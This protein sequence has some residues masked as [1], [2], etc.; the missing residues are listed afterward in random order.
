MVVEEDKNI[1]KV[2]KEKKWQKRALEVEVTTLSF[3]IQIC[4]AS[5][6]MDDQKHK[7]VNL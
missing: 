5:K 2:G 6:P 4:Y 7:S 3:H 1:C